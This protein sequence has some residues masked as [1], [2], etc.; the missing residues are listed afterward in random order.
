MRL[1]ESKEMITKTLPRREVYADYGSFVK[2]T[3]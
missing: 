1:G 2:G 3:A